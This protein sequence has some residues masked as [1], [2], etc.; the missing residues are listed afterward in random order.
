MKWVDWLY[1]EQESSPHLPTRA[2]THTRTYVCIAVYLAIFIEKI[3]SSIHCFGD[4]KK[5]HVSYACRPWNT[6]S[7]S[8]DAQEGRGAIAQPTF[9]CRHVWTS[10]HAQGE[11]KETRTWRLHTASPMQ[12]NPLWVHPLFL[13]LNNTGRTQSHNLSWEHLDFK[14]HP[15]TPTLAPAPCVTLP[16]PAV[17]ARSSLHFYR[18]I[19][20]APSMLSTLDKAETCSLILSLLGATIYD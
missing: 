2:H 7:K 17:C 13:F 8:T 3:L 16:V 6:E 19:V 15:C 18:A 10:S 4:L 9:A 20:A 11:W 1:T 12:W 5:K 14:F